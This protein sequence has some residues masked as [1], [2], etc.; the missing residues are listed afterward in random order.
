MDQTKIEKGL[1]VWFYEFKNWPGMFIEGRLSLPLY[2]EVF[3][4]GLNVY[5]SKNLRLEI[6]RWF[7]QKTQQEESFHWTMQ[8][9]AY[10][11]GQHEDTN[12]KLI[13]ETEEY[14]KTNEIF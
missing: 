14:F 10:Y 1:P 3:V 5:S 6:S 4:D 11:K 8:I 12:K 2:L 13:E 9:N 7:Y